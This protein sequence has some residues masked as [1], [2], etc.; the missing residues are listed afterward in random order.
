MPPKN[1]DQLLHAS[2]IV[3]DGRAVLLRGASGAGKSDITLRL[4][5]ETASLIADDYVKVAVR[6]GVVHVSAPDEI[7]GK[8][9]VRGL[10]ILTFDRT[11]S[12]PLAL[13]VDLVSPG[14]IERMPEPDWCKIA[15]I[16]VPRINLAPFEISATAKLRAAV[17]NCG[18]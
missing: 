1:V 9:E 4:I 17:R 10:G 14:E 6:D 2:A 5:D 16:S 13:V 11:E 7:K 15:D 8:M 18:I 12:A 3:L